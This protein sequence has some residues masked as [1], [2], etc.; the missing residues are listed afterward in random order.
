VAK[1]G[2]EPATHGFSG[3]SEARDLLG[4]LAD[5]GVRHLIAT[6][7]LRGAGEI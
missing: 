6:L 3:I 4:V 7:L 1:A 2:I 5:F